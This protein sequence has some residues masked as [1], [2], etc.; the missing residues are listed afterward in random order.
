MSSKPLLCQVRSHSTVLCL[1]L[2]GP[3]SGCGGCGL[4]AAAGT[5]LGGGGDRVVPE[6][7]IP[8]AGRKGRLWRRFYYLQYLKLLYNKLKTEYAR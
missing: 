4:G 1:S 3:R 6:S 8:A 2:L 7:A 5:F